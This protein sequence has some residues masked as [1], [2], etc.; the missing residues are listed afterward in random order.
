MDPHYN[1]WTRNHRP[2]AMPTFDCVS[3]ID[4]QELKNSVDQANREITNRYDF[5]NSGAIIEETDGKLLLRAQNDF[6]LKQMLEILYTRATKRGLDLKVFAPK[7]PEILG[8]RARQE[9][10][11]RQGIDTDNARRLVKLIKE[12]GLKLQA[13]IQGDTVRV[14]GKKRDDLQAAIAR[15]REAGLDRPLQFVNFRD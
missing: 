9:V 12:S 10:D 6:Q 2:I 7:E 3:K 8:D 15:L 4:L 5:K 14:S 13:S 11:L 1:R